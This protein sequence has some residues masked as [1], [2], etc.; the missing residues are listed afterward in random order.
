[1]ILLDVWTVRGTE[2]ESPV[3]LVINKYTVAVTTKRPF[4]K[5]ARR[6]YHRQTH[7]LN[8]IFYIQLHSQTYFGFSKNYLMNIL[9]KYYIVCLVKKLLSKIQQKK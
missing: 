5:V 2:R 7:Q 1:M 9:F 6:V 8:H 3:C 4:L